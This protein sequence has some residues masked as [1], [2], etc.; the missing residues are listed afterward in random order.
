MTEP[1]DE[2]KFYLGALCPRGHDWGGTGRSLRLKNNRNCVDCIREYQRR[3]WE[4]NPD[5][6]R[7][8]RRRW[9]EE[10]PGKQREYKRRWHERNPGKQRAADRKLREQNPDKYR[11]LRRCWRKENPEAVKAIKHKRRARKAAALYI[12]YSGAELAAHF[13]QFDGCAYCGAPEQT[14]DHLFPLSDDLL[15]A[16]A[17]CNIVPAC[18]RCNSSKNN[19]HPVQ[20]YKVQKFYDPDRLQR[21]I[22]VLGIGE[23]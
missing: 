11:E 21:I 20:W 12:P 17:L 3:W 4:Q 6:Q 13:A 15:A 16:D 14:V 8:Y 9:H 7:E 18:K 23:L 2:S 19:R 10:N 22:D 5:K 1:F